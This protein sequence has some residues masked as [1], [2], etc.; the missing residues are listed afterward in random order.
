MKMA[1]CKFKKNLPPPKTKKKEQSRNKYFGSTGMPL[2]GDIMFIPWVILPILL[3][4]LSTVTYPAMGYFRGVQNRL[5]GA[6]VN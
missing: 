3:N 6:S 1:K 4:V 2:G 5:I